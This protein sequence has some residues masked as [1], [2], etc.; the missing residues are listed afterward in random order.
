[1]T[2]PRINLKTISVNLD[3]GPYV[4]RV[5][6]CYAEIIKGDVMFRNNSLLCYGRE[7]TINW[8]Y[9]LHSSRQVV[10]TDTQ[11]TGCKSNSTSNL[12]KQQRA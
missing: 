7:E 4:I 9:I 5:I 1:M 12:L 10:N 6:L 3:H 2:Y 8:S 11:P